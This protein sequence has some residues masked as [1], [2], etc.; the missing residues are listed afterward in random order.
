M[1]AMMKHTQSQLS[2]NPV[3]VHLA[4]HNRWIPSPL[5]LLAALAAAGSMTT[6]LALPKLRSSIPGF[7]LVEL[8]LAGWLLV[9]ILPAIIAVVTTLLVAQ[10]TRSE[11][12]QLLR[13]TN[14][15]ATIRVNGY[16]AGALYRMRL[17]LLLLVVL[18]PL[19]AQGMI[20]V[21]A[22]ITRAVFYLMYCPPND[23]RCSPYVHTKTPQLVI[24]VEA[25]LL[26]FMIWGLI[27]LAAR[28]GVL[29]GLKWRHNLYAGWFVGIALLHLDITM[30]YLWDLTRWSVWSSSFPLAH[31]GICVSL[32]V[33]SFAIGHLARRWV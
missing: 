18:S 1:Q 15:S 31:L 4:G 14:L 30:I 29:V 28:M 33:L 20:A 9:F 32:F 2:S 3:F 13:L 12:Y 26:P 17:V 19:I 27:L 11:E 22:N 7:S 8:M 10:D 6:L 21:E 25:F 24:M 23:I 16:L 5:V